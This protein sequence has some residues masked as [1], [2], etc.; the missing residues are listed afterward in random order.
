MPSAPAGLLRAAPPCCLLPAAAAAAAAP[1]PACLGLAAGAAREACGDSSACGGQQ[2][3]LAVCALAN[4]C[5]AVEQRQAKPRQRVRK[6]HNRPDGATS[7][8]EERPRPRTCSS[9]LT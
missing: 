5:P 2:E 4:R 3:V 7:S 9:R 8:P 6:L 1:P